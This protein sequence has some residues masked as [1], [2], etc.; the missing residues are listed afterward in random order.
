MNSTEI[1]SIVSNL[2]GEASVTISAVSIIGLLFMLY[3]KYGSSE[4]VSDDTG[5]IMRLRNIS[6]RNTT[7]QV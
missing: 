4:C 3:K 1:S 7:P 5:V 6:R 2:S